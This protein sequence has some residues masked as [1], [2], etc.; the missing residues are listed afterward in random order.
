MRVHP[1][2]NIAIYSLKKNSFS[3][4][5][6]IWNLFPYFF[7]FYVY[8][9]L[10]A[11]MSVYNVH[12]CYLPRSKE[13]V[14]FPETVDAIVVSFHVDGR[15]GNLVLWRSIQCSQPQNHLFST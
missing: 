13:N 3:E 11:C 15:N 6:F 4:K 14:E 8:G 12:A 10:P 9:H 7:Q 5:M 1:F 2:G